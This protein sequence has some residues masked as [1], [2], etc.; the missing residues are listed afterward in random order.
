MNRS[1]FRYKSKEN[2]LNMKITAFLKEKSQEKHRYGY[3]R[4]TVFVREKFGN[5]NH[6]RIH[7]LYVLSKLQLPK[8]RRKRRKYRT[9]PAMIPAAPNELWSMDFVSDRI[10]N[11]RRLRI[12][13]LIDIYTKECVGNIVDTSIGGYRVARELD[14]IIEFRGKPK[15]IV[16]DNGPEFTSG[17]MFD[18]SQKNKV[19]LC[20]I[21]PGKPQ[22]NA[23]VESFNGRMRDECLNVN[24]FNSL[25]EARSVISDWV[26]D[27][28]KYRPHSSLGY[29]TPEKFRLTYEKKMKEINTLSVA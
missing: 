5:I 12:F 9:Q 1:S 26:D 8:S 29:M 20:F 6:K 22:Q 11:G 19:N 2:E 24:L 3:K 21:Q 23:F 4:L 13:N 7:R 15:A 27:Y 17:K 25:L 28:N 18:W 10:E 16:C 14:K